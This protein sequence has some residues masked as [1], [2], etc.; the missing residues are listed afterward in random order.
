MWEIYALERGF[1][2]LGPQLGISTWFMWLCMN[3]KVNK[4]GL[5]VLNLPG[6]LR[7]RLKAVSDSQWVRSCPGPPPSYRTNGLL[8]SYSARWLWLGTVAKVFNSV[9]GSLCELKRDWDHWDCARA[10]ARAPNETI[11]RIHTAAFVFETTQRV[12]SCQIKDRRLLT[13]DLQTC[14]KF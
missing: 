5:T 1:A 3:G 13:S 7:L 2:C 14:R 10:R 12:A 8:M 6:Y 9:L 11:P 4:T